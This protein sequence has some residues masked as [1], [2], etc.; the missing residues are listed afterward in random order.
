MAKMSFAILV[1]CKACNQRLEMVTSPPGH[2]RHLH[3]RCHCMPNDG[4]LCVM[5][6]EHQAQALRA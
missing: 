6:K 5:L 2:D 1:E 3:F 4:M